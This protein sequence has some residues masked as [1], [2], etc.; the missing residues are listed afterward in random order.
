M[1]S[2]TAPARPRVLSGERLEA[3]AVGP[4]GTR[5][6][7]RPYPRTPPLPEERRRLDLER[8]AAWRVGAA[9]GVRVTVRWTSG[10][11]GG[12]SL[13][14]AGAHAVDW[15]HRALAPLYAIGQWSRDPA[16]DGELPPLRYGTLARS[17][18]LPLPF[19]W[20]RPACADVILH[21][22]SLAGPGIEL[23]WQLQPGGVGPAAP[24][25]GPLGPV[26]T[27]DRG[28]TPRPPVPSQLERTV[29]DLSEERQRS[30]AWAAS[31]VLRGAPTGSARDRAVVEDLVRAGTR[32]EGGN[33]LRF[34]GRW[35]AWSG[36]APRFML[37]EPEVAALL[38]SPWARVADPMRSPPGVGLAAGRGLDGAPVR[39]PCEPSEGRHLL[40]LGETGMGKSTLLVQLLLAAQRRAAIVLLD[41]IGDTGRRFLAALDPRAAERATWISP[42]SSPVPLNALEPEGAAS[43]G[44]PSDRARHELVMALRRVRGQRYTEGAFWGPRLEEVLGR[45]LGVAARLPGGT[46]LDAYRL[47]APEGLGRDPADPGVRSELHHLRSLVE[48]RPEEVG[49]ARRLLG[50]VAHNRVL[51][52]LLCAPGSRFEL[53]GC[54]EPGAITVLTGEAA[55]VGESTA[56]YLGAIQLALLWSALLARSRASKVVVALDEAQWFAHDGLLELLR[57]GRRGNVHVWTAT[58]SLRSLGEELREAL[59]TNCADFVLFRGDPEDARLFGRWSGELT[60]E[61]L[62]AL[63]R[64][65][66]AVLVGK[67]S[68]VGWAE[69]RSPGPPIDRPERWGE[70]AARSLARWASAP[71]TAGPDRDPPDRDVEVSAALNAGAGAARALAVAAEAAAKAAPRSAQIALAELRRAAGLTVEEGREL[72][73]DWRRRGI[74]RSSRPGPA[75]PVWELA[76]AGEAAWGP[77]TPPPQPSEGPPDIRRVGNKVL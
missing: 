54:A 15:F 53:G 10:P 65:H 2:R 60:P 31:L 77:A 32:L 35:R 67:G 30:V 50:E 43:R 36:R 17:P 33:A 74:L 47:L 38:P 5:W 63:P 9:L 23:A 6:R 70:I 19:G 1:L 37:S 73:G 45:A 58:Q 26:R 57:L 55:E 59:L 51:S 25:A 11:Q 76:P 18:E 62:L 21:G 71:A 48:E 24:F 12:A 40:V 75:G 66:A 3:P 64:G 68:S 20:E 42:T 4:T 69:T 27:G 8:R 61:R 22:M 16:P 56:R 46:L 28:P 34:G 41:P 52:E 13:E 29:R 14:V 39:L 44:G 49:G 7:F 72:G